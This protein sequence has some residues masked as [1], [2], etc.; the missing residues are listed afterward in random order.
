MHKVIKKGRK[1][2]RKIIVNVNNGS[3]QI[4]FLNTLLTSLIINCAL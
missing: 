3:E 1:N 2:G 4:P